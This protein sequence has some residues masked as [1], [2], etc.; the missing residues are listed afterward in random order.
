MIRDL[1]RIS[2]IALL[3]ATLSACDRHD[4]PTAAPEPAATTGTSP[5]VEHSPPRAV[6]A[7]DSKRMLAAA[8]EPGAWMS[9]GRTYSEQRY[10]PLA[11]INTDNVGTLGL[12]WAYDLQTQRGI[13][14]TSLVVDGVMYTTGAWSMVYALDARSGKLLWSFD[15]KVPKEK[16]KH[17]C[18]EVVNRG[19]A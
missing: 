7:V 4:N 16:A 5:A 18:C 15:P 8:G 19:V 11:Q 17:T 9:Y 13:E 10:S 3:A 1:S 14:A 2:L 12:A 6:A